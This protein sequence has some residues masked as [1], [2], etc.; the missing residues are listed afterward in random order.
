MISPNVIITKNFDTMKRIFFGPQ[1]VDDAKKTN[2]TD[3]LESIE[4]DDATLICA[5]GNNNTLLEIDYNVPQGSNP[6]SYINAKFVET[7]EIIEY[8]LLDTSPLETQFNLLYTLFSKAGIPLDDSLAKLNKFYIAFGTGDDMSQWAGPFAVSLGAANIVLENNVKVVTLGFISGELESIRSY[9]TKL[10]GNLGFSDEKLNTPLPKDTE[11]TYKG[12]EAL[13]YGL[14]ATGGPRIDPAKMKTDRVLQEPFS[15]N[16]F[17]RSMLKQFLG[18]IYGAW[19]RVMV[20]LPDDFNKIFNSS[21]AGAKSIDFFRNY[22]GKLREFG[23]KLRARS[24]VAPTDK[25]NRNK[26]TFKSGSGSNFRRYGVGYNLD[27]REISYIGN[28][29]GGEALEKYY[30]G[31]WE[32]QG[33]SDE[34]ERRRQNT[35]TLLIRTS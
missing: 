17:V 27:E 30:E 19:D 20:L 13:K 35:W 11:V 24:P 18:K 2:L 12:V 9:T 4:E 14:K 23:I 8:F 33:N 1:G 22:Q 32:R 31:Y 5:P 7:K 26:R 15:W 28:Q 6:N 10:Y 21:V 25:S 29:E 34:C 16:P 3:V